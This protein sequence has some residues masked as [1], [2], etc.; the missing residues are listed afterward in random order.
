VDTP[1]GMALAS[2]SF[3]PTLEATIID[4]F[5]GRFF[6]K[7]AAGSNNKVFIVANFT[8]C[9]GFTSSAIYDTASHALSNST[10][11]I[12]GTA[13]ASADGTRIYVRLSGDS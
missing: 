9:S 13:A 12:N 8:E 11:L 3:I 1:H 6:D 10:S 7:A 4:T 5:C 2:G